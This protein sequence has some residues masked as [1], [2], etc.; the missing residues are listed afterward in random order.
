MTESV[1][2]RVPLVVGLNVTLIVQLADLAP[3]V[4]PHGV[5]SPPTAA[6]S[7]VAANESEVDAVP[8]FFTVTVL[9]ALVVPTF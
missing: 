7:P 6:K 9:A 4:V 2:V 1:P 5:V 8:V 3:S